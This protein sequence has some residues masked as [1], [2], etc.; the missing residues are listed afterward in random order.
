MWPLK[1]TLR[2]RTPTKQVC[3]DLS[4]NVTE[5]YKCLKVDKHTDFTLQY[6]KTRT[7]RKYPGEL[8]RKPQSLSKY[9]WYLLCIILIIQMLKYTICQTLLA[10]CKQ[11]NTCT[12]NNFIKTLNTQFLI[13]NQL[14]LMGWNL[15]TLFDPFNRKL[16]EHYKTFI[17]KPVN[18]L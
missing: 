17:L 13:S 1:G 3:N 12:Y 10:W 6:F 2:Q 16:N 5:C 14:H 11:S 9:F 18:L 15:N 4:R 8:T 7:F